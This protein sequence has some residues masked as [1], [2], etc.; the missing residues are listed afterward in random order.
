MGIKKIRRNEKYMLKGSL[1]KNGF[2]CWRLVTNAIS[3]VT[4][5]E[6]TFFIEYYIVNPSVSPDECLL[7]FKNRFKKTAADLQ[8]ALAGTQSTQSVTSQTF[9]QPSFLMVRA[10][11]FAEN[12][13]HV[14]AYYPCSQLNIGTNDFLIC[15]GNGE[16]KESILSD[17]FTQGR[18]KV[19]PE[20][21]MENPEYLCDAGEIMW[22]LRFDK[23]I[24]FLPDY[25]GKGIHWAAFGAKTSFSG[26]I[27]FNGEEFTVYPG[28]SFGYFDKN[29]GKAFVNPFFHLSSSNFTSNISGMNLSSSCFAVQ[30]EFNKKLSVLVQVEGKKIQFHADRHR[31]Y[32]VTY[33]FLKM[34]ENEEDV[35]LHWTVSAHNKKY[36]IDVDIFSSVKAVSVRDFECPEGGRKVLK[37]LG[38][39]N[40][41]GELRIYKKIVKNLELIEDV[42]IANCLCEYGNIEYPES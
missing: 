40:G 24:G 20:F 13:R 22:D 10:G 35:K 36:V 32:E 37:V 41:T 27:L 9:V 4:G 25:R 18:V 8:Y 34:P 15:V 7:G 16:L 12:G 29:W 17:D 26:R 5:E 23:K 42:K 19:L 1:K 38:G 28:I 31:N 11:V 6:K 21:L 14:S 33:D 3:N 30:G 39:A 2:D